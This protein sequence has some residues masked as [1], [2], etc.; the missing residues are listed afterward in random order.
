MSPQRAV[1]VAVAAAGLALAL[2]LLALAALAVRLASPGPALYWAPRVGQGGHVFR[3]CKLRT[4]HVGA[5][6]GAAITAP[7]DPRVFRI[8]ALL[9]AGKIDELPQL[10]NV[11]RGEMAL[12]GPRPED[13]GLVARHYG[14]LE[15]STLAVRPG[16][17]SPG[18]LFGFTHGDA[19]LDPAD[20]VGSYVARLMPT[21]LRLEAVYVQNRSLAYDLQVLARTGWIL[22]QRL[23]GRRR[24]PAPRELAAIGALDETRAGSAA[25]A[26][27]PAAGR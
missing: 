25:A 15:R 4:M 11:L 5:D 9:R 10:W 17:T 8:G 6:R 22:G 26:P 16:L 7:G 20:P 24:F 21:K 13:P 3:M 14:P 27:P 23:L 19:L 1:D 12:V 18:A 2:P